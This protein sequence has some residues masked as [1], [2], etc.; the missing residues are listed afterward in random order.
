MKKYYLILLC[1]SIPCACYAQNT[2]LGELFPFFLLLLGGV[3]LLLL[4]VA[5]LYI[6]GKI[7]EKKKRIGRQRAGESDDMGNR[8]SNKDRSIVKKNKELQDDNQK[9]RN[10]ISELEQQLSQKNTD[11]RQLNKEKT[12]LED[13]I[14]LMSRSTNEQANEDSGNK[15]N[16][17]DERSNVKIEN[18]IPVVSQTDYND[19][20]V[21]NG[22]LVKAEYEHTIYYHSWRSD[23]K[24]LYEFVNNERTRKA[25][26]NR[27]I[28]IEPF[29]IK[30]ESSKSPD[31]SEEIETMVPG[32]LNEDY[33]IAKKAEIIYK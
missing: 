20:T 33:T 15:Q 14:K 17:G 10:K 9:L 3:F 8:L 24:L 22:N 7:N 12:R 11:I 16:I 1:I 30:Q 31:V 29:C 6:N 27:T 2:N 26:N 5:W 4:F 18:K 32:I 25:I 28:I 13:R 19:L 23:G 21:L